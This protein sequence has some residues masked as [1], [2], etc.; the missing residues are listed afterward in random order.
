MARHTYLITVDNSD[1]RVGASKRQGLEVARALHNASIPGVNIYEAPEAL[2]GM[3]GE[4]V[5]YDPARTV[6]QQMEDVEVQG[7]TMKFMGEEQ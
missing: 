3:A 1:N 6:A 4:W 5:R 2:M 7:G